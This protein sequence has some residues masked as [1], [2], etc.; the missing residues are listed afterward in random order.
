M[1]IV[2]LANFY[3]PT[4]GGQ[5]TALDETGRRYQERGVDT[6]LVVPG[7]ADDD[8]FG[9]AGR[10]ITLSSHSL[11]R[12]PYH[13]LTDLRGVR[14]LVSDLRPD[15]LELSDRST[16]W[17]V[18]RWA[19]HAGLPLVLWVHERVESMLTPRLP[20]R[21]PVA[22]ASRSWD[23]RTVR[24][25]TRAVAPTEF[26]AAPI[27][28]AGVPDVR[29]VPHG[30]DLETFHPS[31]RPPARDREPLLVW[32]GRLSAEKQP[33]LAVDAVAE[34][35]RRGVTARLVMVGGGGMSDSL[36]RRAEGLPVTFTGHIADRDNLAQLL[37]AADVALAT[38][39][40]ESFGLSALEALACGTPVVAADQGGLPEVVDPSSGRLAGP[41]SES[42]A[43]AV[44]D[45]LRVPTEFRVRL[46]RRRA[47][48][49]SWDATVDG[50]LDAHE[51]VRR[52]EAV[53]A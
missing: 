12:T 34:L 18:A 27:R 2:R 4:S 36:H 24:W 41:T 1:R 37:A 11:P 31:R 7:A 22:A 9:P 46:A 39:P 20:S 17:P 53:P 42:F 45:L 51:H 28:D 29:V 8:S 13:L 44:E 43:D 35:H 3:A 30:V 50:L 47:V 33:E 25:V 38:C 5:R 19:A 40:G 48:R 26:A 32:V 52:P 21:L 6:V 16:L 23:R 14:H 10:R 15:R 49:F